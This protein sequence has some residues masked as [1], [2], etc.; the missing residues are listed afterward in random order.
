MT[1]LKAITIKD[2]EEY[3]RQKS[4][5]VDIMNDTNLDND[6]DDNRENADDT[7]IDDTAPDDDT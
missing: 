5:V 3:L 4:L 2:N 7:N 1:K 6:I